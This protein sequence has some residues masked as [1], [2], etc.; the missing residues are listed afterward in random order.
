MVFA[1]PNE[2]IEV[3]YQPRSQRQG[4]E[5]APARPIYFSLDQARSKRSL[6]ITLV[7]AAMKSF[8]NFSFESAQA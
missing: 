5:L 4:R 6:F 1:G 8:T 3:K 2:R 7:H